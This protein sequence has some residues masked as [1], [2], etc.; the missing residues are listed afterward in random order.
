MP[1]ERRRPVS[2]RDEESDKSPGIDVSLPTSMSTVQTLQTSL[3]AKAKAPAFRFYSLWDKVYRADVLRVAYRRCRA[4]R[5]APGYDG[6]SFKQIEDQGLD[7][8]LERLRQEL[9]A[10]EYRPQPVTVHTPKQG[11][12][13]L[14]MGS[15]SAQ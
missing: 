14:G 4:N 9:Q 6:I 5:G 3:E 1:E 13:V 15:A 7:E 8:W 10:G 12:E 11:A 2:K